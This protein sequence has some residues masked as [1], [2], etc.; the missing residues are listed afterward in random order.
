LQSKKKINNAR[1]ITT[2][3]A[4]NWATWTPL[5]VLKKNNQ[6]LFY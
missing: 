6:F 2:Q 1:Q 3:K 5:K 4:K